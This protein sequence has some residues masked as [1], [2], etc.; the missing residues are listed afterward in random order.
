MPRAPYPTRAAMVS[1]LEPGVLI[2]SGQIRLLEKREEFEHIDE[3][4]HSRV[5][6]ISLVLAVG[7]LSYQDAHIHLVPRR[8]L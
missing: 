4:A 8:T 3:L 2:E 7:L 5:A 6:A 1:S